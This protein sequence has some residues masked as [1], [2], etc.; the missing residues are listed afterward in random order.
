MIM[1]SRHCSCGLI[2][3]LLLFCALGSTT[4]ETL[5]DEFRSSWFNDL[6]RTWVGRDYHA[7][8]WQDWRIHDGRLECLETGERLPMR[9]VQVL[10][11]VLDPTIGRVELSVGLGEIESDA[12]YSDNAW[13]GLLIGSGGPDIDYRRTAL[14]HHLPAQDGGIMAV[15]D[16]RGIVSIRDN[17]RE[18]RGR[19]TWVI[20]GD[21]DGTDLPTLPGMESRVEIDSYRIPA[22]GVELRVAIECVDGACTVDARVLDSEGDQVISRARVEDVPLSKVRGSFGVISHHGP[23]KAT[24]GWWFRG[25]HAEGPGIVSVSGREFG[26][27]LGVLYT[28]DRNTMT[29]VAQ[30]PPIGENDTREAT[31][32]IQPEPR[33]NW[34]SVGTSP[35]DMDSRTARFRVSEWNSEADIPYR[36]VYKLDRRDGT[37]AVDEYHGT[38]RKEPVAGTPLSIGSLSCHKTYTGGLAWNGDG[39]WFPH[40][41]LY[42]VV[43]RA[44]PDMLFFAGDQIYEGDLTPANQKS[45]DAFILDYLWKY[46]HWLWAFGDLTRDRPTIVIP[47]DH[48]VYHGNIWGAQG[49]R[50]RR[51]PEH[52][53][54]DSGGYKRPPRF[55]NA[56][57][58]TQVGNLPD[59]YDPGMIGEGYSVYHTDIE[60]GG[61]SFAVIA[62]RQF[63]DS[64]TIAVPEGEV[65]NGWF[66]AKGFDVIEDGDAPNASL[67][68]ESQERFLE[69]WAN[70]WNED[71][72][73]KVLLSQTP[74]ACVQTLPVGAKG[75]V[76]PAL[77]IFEPG[78]FAV[79]DVPCSDADSNGWPMTGRDRALGIIQPAHVLHL[80]GDQHIGFAAQYGVESQRDGGVVFCSPAIANTWPRRWMPRDPE[81]N[82][83]RPL[84]EHVDGFGNMVAI[85]AVANPFRR[86]HEP[87]ALHDRS[88]GFGLVRL[89]PASHEITLEAWPRA[90]GLD[91]RVAQY[92]GWPLR[93]RTSDLVGSTWEWAL[94]PLSN[95]NITIPTGALCRI[96]APAADDGVRDLVRIIR[97]ND[98][99]HE[100][101]LRVP[102]AG[103]YDIEVTPIAAEGSVD[104][105]SLVAQPIDE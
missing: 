44:D 75:G 103:A 47:D 15:V 23:V 9:T 98:S 65:R 85:D 38:I 57:H 88:P 95:S 20:S 33:A 53:A 54:Q 105:F 72:W 6:D 64:P 3:F 18:V 27:I 58:R 91:D 77:T 79:D 87:S 4:G 101:P 36:V 45:E 92:E 14:V 66:T 83:P 29:M 37:I 7:N 52:S 84:G 56:V 46:T 55:V 96:M 34:V 11:E 43:E 63:K 89:E 31:L 69:E 26:P 60:Y 71:V 30:F 35:I 42:R 100:V 13:G 17:E 80:C 24:T 86:G 21:V 61:V 10:P 16:G 90:A 25:L 93:Y 8:R 102:S 94:P 49:R 99:L 97:W 22:D 40:E 67:L 48:D 28:L 68:G 82:E 19:S 104:S 51:T 39:L 1:S 32:Q 73:M 5:G 78:G 41:E 2:P 50:A 12:S 81:T 76:Q 74:F 62:D 59:P 70:D